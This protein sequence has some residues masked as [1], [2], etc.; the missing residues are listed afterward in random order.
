MLPGAATAG[1]WSSSAAR[2]RRRADE[3]ARDCM[4]RLRKQKD[5]P[6]DEAVSTTRAEEQKTLGGARGRPGRHRLFRRTSATTGRA[7]RTPPS[8]RSGWA[9]TCATSRSF[10]T[11]TTTTARSTAT[12]A[13]AASTAASTSTCAPPG[14]L[15]VLAPSWTRPPIWSSRYGGSLSGEHGDGQPR[16]ELLPKMYGDEL[17]EAFR[18]F[19]A[20]WDP[21]GPDEP[22]TRS[23]T[24]IRS[25]ET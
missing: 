5:A 3:R 17:V 25:I 16:A 14:G 8:R 4:A 19:K 12:S 13:R 23:S 18:E 24:P 6:D 2:R 7:G 10:S 21:D 15:R 9:T 1:C 11:A 22:A 20:I